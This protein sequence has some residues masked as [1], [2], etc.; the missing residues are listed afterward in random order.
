VIIYVFK[1]NHLNCRTTYMINEVLTSLLI[2][3]IKVSMKATAK[4]S[5]VQIMNQILLQ[6]NPLMAQ[7]QMAKQRVLWQ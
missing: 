7:V 3:S 6:P 4:L 2:L 5:Q 1:L